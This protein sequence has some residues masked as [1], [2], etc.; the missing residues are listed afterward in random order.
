MPTV[1]SGHDG[2][3][4]WA[5]TLFAPALVAVVLT[6]FAW[7]A[8]RLAPHDLPI[9]VAGPAAV[10]TGVAQSLTEAAGPDAFDVHR[11]ADE[12]AAREAIRDREVYGAVVAGPGG[13]TLLTASAAS[14]L[15]SGL[16]TQALTEQ[17]AGADP[18][19]RPR[20]VD[21]VPTTADD[22]R[23]VVFGSALLPLV[24][25]GLVTGALFGLRTRPGVKQAVAIL[26][27]SAL[28]GLVVAGIAQGW[29]GALG[30]DWWVNATAAGLTVLAIAAAVAGAVAVVGVAGA[31]LVAVLLMVV[32]NP[33]SGVTS[34]PELLPRWA[35]V[36][37]QL[38]PPGAGGT[39]L[40]GTSFFDGAGGGR[41]LVV[42][43]V[44]AVVGLTCVLLGALR[45]H[46]DPV[47]PAR[48]TA[49]AAAA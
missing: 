35:G 5:A 37:G 48:H 41:P 47:E 30:G 9:G 10:A 43:G 33:L 49:T 25:A 46:G 26:V 39:L 13:V 4:L 14:P 32:G 44:W 40:R 1:S 6:M 16:M 45:R 28:A 12:A 20:V 19:M 24:M 3:R 11:Y 23:G 2:R 15:V 7:P 34:A 31:G 29:L 36:T 22:P 21:V 8:S 42:L 38:L 27:S 17:A 18:A